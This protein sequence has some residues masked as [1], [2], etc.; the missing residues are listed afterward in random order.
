MNRLRAALTLAATLALMLVVILA[1]A[2]A[3]A[4]TTP[5]VDILD[6]FNP[7]GRGPAL[8]RRQLGAGRTWGS[9]TPCGS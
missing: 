3:A 1:S 6:D 4:P 5:L 8:G 2:A 7:P 9:G